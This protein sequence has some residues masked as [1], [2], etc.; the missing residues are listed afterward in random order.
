MKVKVEGCYIMNGIPLGVYSVLLEDITVGVFEITK[1]ENTRTYQI[2]DMDISV[3]S[4]DHV[5]L[6]SSFNYIFTGGFIATKNNIMPIPQ[7]MRDLEDN[8]YDTLTTEMARELDSELISSLR[9][10]RIAANISDRIASMHTSNTSGLDVNGS[11]NRSRRPYTPIYDY[12]QTL[13]YIPPVSISST[14][15]RP[16]SYIDCSDIGGGVNENQ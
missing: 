6:E 12:P 11:V 9:R 14:I 10:S 16:V 8:L 7:T 3:L 5:M 1:V 2:V 15:P 13:S 4:I